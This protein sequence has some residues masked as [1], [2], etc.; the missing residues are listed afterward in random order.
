MTCQ[1]TMSTIK[2]HLR[3]IR[4]LRETRI[5]DRCVWT[6]QLFQ[7]LFDLRGAICVEWSSQHIEV[8]GVMGDGHAHEAASGPAMEQIAD[9]DNEGPLLGRHLVPC[10]SV[11]HLHRTDWETLTRGLI[12]SGFSTNQFFQETRSL[13]SC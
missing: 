4:P 5:I 3:K 2:S 6:S 10:A 12:L 7:T 8:E 1:R 9:V 13:L 11:P